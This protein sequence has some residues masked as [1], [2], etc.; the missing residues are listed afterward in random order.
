VKWRVLLVDDDRT[1]AEDILLHLGDRFEFMTLSDGNS[2]IS[3]VE[4]HLPDV[5]LLDIDLGAG[6]SG[7]EI[8]SR[9]RED[10]PRVPVIM[11][12][13]YD[14]TEMGADAWRR[15][16]FGYI[17]K[18][19]S[20]DELAARIER[21]VEEAVAYRERQAL[22]EEIQDLVGNLIGESPAIREI[23]GLI[24]QVAPTDATVLISGETGTG[25]EII[26]RA[27]HEMSPRRERLLVPV[28]CPAIPETLVESELFGHERGAFTGATTRKIGKFQ[29]AHKGT[30]FLDE[31]G[32]IPPAVQAKLLRVLEDRKF[33]PVGSTKEIDV[34]V[35]IL[36]AT[37]RDLDAEV[38][39]RSF[40]DDLYYR[41]RVVP[42]HAPPL[43]ERKEDIPLLA[44]HMLDLMTRK[45]NRPR[46]RL[47]AR[48]L[49]R[50]L[51]W[52]WR[53]NVREL[54]NVLEC[55]LARS[56]GEVLDEDVF[57]HLVCPDMPALTYKEARRR[58]LDRF[59]SE[60][61][62]LVLRERD[63]N[64][65]MAAKRMGLTRE[66]LRKLMKRL[67]VTRPPSHTT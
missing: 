51:A 57:M 2:V 8:M 44:Q 20:T 66:G 49:D 36:A 54:K 56:Q 3:T 33:S 61:T 67:G 63:W 7:L 21:A 24:A 14:G 26:A 23:R 52:D 9:M 19:C 30:L 53:G 37:N 50:F 29:I 11:V 55:A 31:V 47:S 22:R 17:T 5:V 46:T 65:S 45:L 34:D 62:R 60:Y 15:G 6:P 12:T 1:F 4:N 38:A 25:K 39:R 32:E 40:R 43:R 10:L 13:R 16:I 58:V 42:I 41:L 27:I 18:S 48:A 64:I 59:D 28:A 35:R